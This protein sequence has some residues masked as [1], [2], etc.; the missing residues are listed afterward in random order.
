MAQDPYDDIFAPLSRPVLNS[1]VPEET[2]GVYRPV[3]TYEE[4]DPVFDY[5]WYGSR[6]GE[7]PDDEEPNVTIPDSHPFKLTGTF[8]YTGGTVSNIVYSV[9][10]GNYQRKGQGSVFAFAGVAGVPYI[11][12]AP[13]F[14]LKIPATAGTYD[15]KVGATIVQSNTLP[16]QVY[17]Q[18]EGTAT[19]PDWYV[20]VHIGSFTGPGKV[21]GTSG[22]VAVNQV[23]TDDIEYD[24]KPEEG[25]FLFYFNDGTDLFVNLEEALDGFIRGTNSDWALAFDVTSL[26]FD[27]TWS[28]EESTTRYNAT[29]NSQTVWR[30]PIVTENRLV[31]NGGVFEEVL[32][33]RSS[34]PVVMFNKI[35]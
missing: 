18:N 10:A 26:T 3:T 19:S 30:I 6:G 12:N 23:Q 13:H 15:A 22:T 21:E 5:P 14:F 17:I 11:A 20:Y 32:S 16:E 8:D 2:Y 34:S 31:C 33:C 28:G 25:G 4:Q 1:E 29:G 35:G 9:E 7:A 27:K 24:L